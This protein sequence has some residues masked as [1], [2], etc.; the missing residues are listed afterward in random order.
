MDVDF[1]TIFA[2]LSPKF[3]PLTLAIAML[4]NLL[5]W[6]A[7]A[8]LAWAT[9]PKYR[10]AE[11]FFY[12]KIVQRSALSKREYFHL[13]RLLLTHIPYFNKL[14]TQGRARFI[15]RVLR[16][17]RGR[18][19]EGIRGQQLSHDMPILVSAAA[20]Q[21]TFGLED[22]DIKFL[23]KVRIAPGPIYSRMFNADVY[24]SVSRRGTMTLSWPHFLKGFANG[25]DNFNLGLHE[26]A[27]ALKL[28][29]QESIR[30]DMRFANYLDQ[31]QRI[32]FDA[33]TALKQRTPGYLDPYG[34]T[35]PHE[36]FAVCIEHFFETPEQFSTQLPDVFNH[37][38]KLLN[39][40]PLNDRED[41]KLSPYFKQSI[42]N[43]PD[44]IPLPEK[45][46]KRYRPDDANRFHFYIIP[47]FAI[48][49]ITAVPAFLHEPVNANGLWWLGSIGGILALF[50]QL[51]YILEFKALQYKW[52]L[53]YAAALLCLSNATYRFTNAVITLNHNTF[54]LNP[55]HIEAI[56]S[57]RYAVYFSPPPGYAQ[58]FIKIE[59]KAE[60]SLMG[61]MKLQL[62]TRT[63]CMGFE[64]LVDQ[65]H[66]Y[67]PE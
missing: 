18:T 47:A 59:A 27:H 56:G 16:F 22:Y 35:N 4:C 2:R 31:W 25:E 55:A 63:G 3:F 51:P 67:L 24:G 1:K 44:R 54:I 41:F 57:G 50:I 45:I 17:M 26:L 49:I 28:D 10:E 38:C 48:S 20:V 8:G 66:H 19:F 30:F 58:K 33:F 39:Q 60:Q 37:L 36:F 61:R 11:A 23:K 14:S 21:L 53:I 29:S 34:G 7:A 15:A 32:G 12:S 46:K 9:G 62:R 5:F 64:L 65:Q 43:D 13:E 52:L 42:A 6:A 40:N